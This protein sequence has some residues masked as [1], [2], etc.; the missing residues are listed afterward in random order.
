MENITSQELENLK[1]NNIKILVDFWGS[2]C[3]P[4]KILLPILESIESDYPNIKFVKVD[5]DENKGYITSLGI[6]SIP[7]VLLY[8][9]LSLVT[10]TIGVKSEKYYRESLQLLNE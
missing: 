9:G 5:I 3:Q 8:N 1:A 4:C 2:W 7:A 6:R 10:V